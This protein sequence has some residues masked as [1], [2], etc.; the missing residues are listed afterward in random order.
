MFA[1][2]AKCVL[3]AALLAQ[4]SLPSAAAEDK[5]KAKVLLQEGLSFNRQREHAQALEKFQAAYAAY[6]SPKL[7]F[8]IGQVQLTL[9]HPVEAIEAFEKFLALVPD[10][11][12]ED[13]KVAKSTVAQ[14]GKKL[15]RLQIK[16]ETTGAEVVINGKSVGRVPMQGPLWAT[17]GSHQVTITHEGSATVTENVEMRAGATALVVI[18]LVPISAAAPAAPPPSSEANPTLGMAITSPDA[19]GAAAQVAPAKATASQAAGRPI[20]VGETVESQAA[21]PTPAPFS[22]VPPA[23]PVATPAAL[24]LS[25]QPAPA[26]GQSRSQPVY[27]TWWFWTGATVVVAGAATTIFLLTDK[28]SSNVPGTPLGNHG[29]FQ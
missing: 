28:G 12:P 11:Q 8:N 26:E 21:G 22:N 3:L 29:V 6:P 4:A 14:L 16:C 1:I 23:P 25:A 2:C 5:A 24:D 10:A 9:D 17:P 27:K 18:R 19:T 13:K 7:W 20:S 15:G